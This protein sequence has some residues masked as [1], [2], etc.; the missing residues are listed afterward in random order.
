MRDARKAVAT[1]APARA[2]VRPLTESLSRPSPMTAD[3]PGGTR[4]AAWRETRAC[5]SE[6]WPGSRDRAAPALRAG[7]R[8]PRA[9]E[10]RTNVSTC[11]ETI[12]TEDLRR[13]SGDRGDI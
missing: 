7:P 10:R 1:M 11:V 12:L 13:A 4:C 8:H 3:A 6:S 9:D 2:R 5:R